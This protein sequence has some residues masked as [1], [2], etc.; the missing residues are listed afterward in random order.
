MCN[1]VISTHPDD[2]HIRRTEYLDDRMK[3]INFY[4]VKNETQQGYT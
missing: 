4:S 1:I 3:I 2:D